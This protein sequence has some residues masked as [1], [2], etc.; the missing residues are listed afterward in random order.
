[1]DLENVVLCWIPAFSFIARG[2]PSPALD[3]L[4]HLR[5]SQ[6]LLQA[7]P[8]PAGQESSSAVLVNQ[9]DQ[10]QLINM[11]TLSSLSPYRLVVDNCQ[12]ALAV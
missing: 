6:L 1:M 3:C 9:T 7:G 10:H 2:D 11:T 4:P 8:G 5:L 12:L